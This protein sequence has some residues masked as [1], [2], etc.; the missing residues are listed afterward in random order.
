MW[1]NFY[2][3]RVHVSRVFQAGEATLQANVEQF[4]KYMLKI[5][6]QSTLLNESTHVKHIKAHLLIE[7]EW[8]IYVKIVKG[9]NQTVSAFV[10]FVDVCFRI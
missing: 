3:F 1:P 6:F 2:M 4:W 9:E 8:G 10:H 5:L 7:E